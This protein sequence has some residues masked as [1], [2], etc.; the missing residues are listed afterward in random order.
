MTPVVVDSINKNIVYGAALDVFD[1]ERDP[2]PY[3]DL[4]EVI[5][6]PHIGSHTIETRK[7]MEEMASKNIV[8]YDSLATSTDVTKISETLSYIDKHSVNYEPN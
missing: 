4:D 6:T 8:I 1:E 5:L 2:Y 3:G 7:S